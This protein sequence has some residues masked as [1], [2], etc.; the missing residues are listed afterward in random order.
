MVVKAHSPVPW[1]QKAI[2]GGTALSTVLVAAAFLLLCLFVQGSTGAWDASF[3]SYPDEAGHVVGAVMVRDY[4]AS[5]LSSN[6]IHFARQYYNRYPFFGV[7]YWPPLYYMVTGLW[8]LAAGVGRFQALLVS[9]GAAT[10]M[11]CMLYGLTRK[12]AGLIA[13]FCAGVLFLSLPEVQRWMCAV[14]VD[15]MV[16]FFCLA[17]AVLLLNYFEQPGLRN[18]I[19]CGLCCGCATLTKYSG[20]YV[21]V[22]PLAACICL[23]RFRLLRTPAFLAQYLV[24]ALL[25]GPWVVWTAKLALVGLPRVPRYTIAARMGRYLLELYRIFPPVLAVVVILGLLA[26]MVMPRVW[27][28]ALVMIGL[29]CAGCLVSLVVAPV[30]PEPRY[31]LVPSAALLALSFAGWVA[32]LEPLTRRGPMGARA[33]PALAAILTLCMAVAHLRS[34]QRPLAYPIR[35]V[36]QAIV[37]NPAWVDKRIIVAPDLEG[38]MIA[39]FAMQDRHRPGYEL[40]RP[41]KLFADQGWFGERYVSRFQS[42]AEMMAD[43]RR[44]PVDLIVWHLPSRTPPKAHVRYMDEML[45][46]YPLAWQRVVSFGSTSGALS[47]WTVYQFVPR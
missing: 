35:S 12:R 45:R 24:M 30:A 39:E 32:A 25:V 5:G 7:G 3:D 40:L 18:A 26:L 23:R 15:E 2:A 6:P 4:L 14:M 28:A 19:Y 22:L 33:V 46:N 31:L 9:A 11:A 27:R 36:V 47:S 29:L 37:E 17:A 1:M 21:C 16:G 43:L 10:G 41:S 44:D 38:P 20:A 13:G 8:L 42:S 34:Y